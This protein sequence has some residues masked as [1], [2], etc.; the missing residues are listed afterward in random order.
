MT[1]ERVK[2]IC[3]KGKYLEEARKQKAK[4]AKLTVKKT[5]RKV[6]LGEELDGMVHKYVQ[7]MLNAETPSGA[8][9]MAAAQG[10]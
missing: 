9:V 10:V 4:V 5:G 8:V 1:L 7:A 2:C 6:L 3:L